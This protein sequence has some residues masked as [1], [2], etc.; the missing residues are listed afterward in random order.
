MMV[1]LRVRWSRRGR[2]RSLAASTSV[3][4]T[5]EQIFV[6]GS[7][8]SRGMT[9]VLVSAVA[10]AGGSLTGLRLI[11]L[12]VLRK[13]LGPV[14]HV[15]APVSHVSGKAVRP[16]VPSV[17][18]PQVIAEIGHHLAQVEPLVAAAVSSG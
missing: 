4:N 17:Q 13:I 1:W 16:F 5:L 15:H 7:M 6:V 10:R 12:C 3:K 11:L 8:I 18:L 9:T 2:L 14:S